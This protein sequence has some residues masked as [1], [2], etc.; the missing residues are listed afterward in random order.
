MIHNM[1]CGSGSGK[2]FAVIAVTYPEGSVCTCSNGA[3][4]LKAKDTSGKALFNVSVGEWTVTATDGSSTA[5]QAVS[6]TTE[7][8]SE[9]VTLLY[10]LYLFKSG[11]GLLPGYSIQRLVS[12]SGD[13]SGTDAIIWATTSQTDS[14]NIFQFQPAVDISEYTKLNVELMCTGRYSSSYTNVIIALT[15][16]F[17]SGESVSTWDTL[18]KVATRN[19]AYNTNRHTVSID[20]SSI[21]SSSYVTINANAISGEVYNVWFE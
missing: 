5:S 14:G 19:D 1:V 7:G 4:T 2:L 17:R 8:Q 6:I 12:G 15:E 3:K 9:S 10:G 18:S 20:V 16:K 21:S 11:D 13:F